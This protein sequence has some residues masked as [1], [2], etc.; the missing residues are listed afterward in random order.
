M[1]SQINWE[2]DFREEFQFNRKEGDTPEEKFYGMMLTE[3]L[4]DF[5]RK[6]K[7]ASRK[8]GY[9]EGVEAVKL[10]EKETDGTTIYATPDDG[11]NT[12]VSDLEQLKIKLLS[13]KL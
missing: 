12:A 4:I 9:R 6:Q 3:Q 1:N 11:Y 7:E 2:D 5:I 13:A 8:S 10:E